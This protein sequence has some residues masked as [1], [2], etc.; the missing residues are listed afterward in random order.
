MSIYDFNEP[1][2]RKC[3]LINIRSKLEGQTRCHYIFQ[4]VVV[5]CQAGK[6]NEYIE[7]ALYVTRMVY[8]NQLG[9]KKNESNVR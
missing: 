1:S 9:N 2:Q 5:H 3:S 8:N 7:S 4:N 6:R